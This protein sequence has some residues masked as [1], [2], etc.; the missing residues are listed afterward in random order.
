MLIGE[1]LLMYISSSSIVNES[2]S[3][4]I[5]LMLSNDL[6]LSNPPLLFFLLI[7]FFNSSLHSRCWFLLF[8]GGFFGKIPT[9]ISISGLPIYRNDVGRYCVYI[10]LSVNSTESS[11]LCSKLN[12]LHGLFSFTVRSSWYSFKSAFFF[13]IVYFE[14]HSGF[15]SVIILEGVRGP[16]I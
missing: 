4:N 12:F 13:W 16:K 7:N 3:L 11:M 15:L 5:W 9:Y 10:L 6:V 2:F 14:P 1:S 8:S